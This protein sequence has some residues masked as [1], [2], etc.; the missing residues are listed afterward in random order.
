MLGCWGVAQQPTKK[1]RSGQR[2]STFRLYTTP[3][4]T[5]A[6]RSVSENDGAD[7]KAGPEG[8]CLPTVVVRATM[9]TGHPSKT[10]GA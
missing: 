10:A 1:A 7:C 3:L 8:A 4:A 6:D 5:G 9:M 2:H